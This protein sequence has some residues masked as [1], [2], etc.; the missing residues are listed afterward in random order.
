MVILDAKGNELT[1]SHG[2]DGNIGCPGT[3]DEIDYFVSMI[4][5][6]SKTNSQD[7]LNQIA[8]ALEESAERRRKARSQTS[9]PN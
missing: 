8:T 5:K 7:R 3:P 1:S 6:T 4:E 2:P 9:S